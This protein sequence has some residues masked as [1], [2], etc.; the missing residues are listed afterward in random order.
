ME[1]SMGY[2]NLFTPTVNVI[3]GE[4]LWG[5][6]MSLPVEEN[7][8]TKGTKDEIAMKII[9]DEKI[10]GEVKI[11]FESIKNLQPKYKKFKIS[12]TND[13]AKK[14]GILFLDISYK[15]KQSK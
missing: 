13:P 5:E 7:N 11:S 15:D 3:A 10:I 9:V 14:I 2:K 12:D 1:I 8:P 6:E 4:L